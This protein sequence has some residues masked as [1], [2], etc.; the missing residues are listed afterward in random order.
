MIERVE[1]SGR[2]REGSQDGQATRFKDQ[3]QSQ[4]Y[5]DESDIF[6]ATIGEQPFEGVFGQ[7]I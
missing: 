1:E 2:K 4:S 5:K 3:C 7:R 6:N